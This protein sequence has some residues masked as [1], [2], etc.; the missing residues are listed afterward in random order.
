MGQVALG[1]LIGHQ[2][3]VPVVEQ[4]EVVAVLACQGRHRSRHCELVEVLVQDPGQSTLVGV[5]GLAVD[6]WI[7]P[8]ISSGRLAHAAKDAGDPV[9]VHD[10]QVV[11]L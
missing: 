5:S 6:V 10:D 1:A 7:E 8:E 9:V 3:V 4:P 11:A 2:H